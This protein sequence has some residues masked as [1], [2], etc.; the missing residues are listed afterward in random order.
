MSSIGEKKT[1]GSFTNI[2]KKK[3]D[4]SRLLVSAVNE[5]HSKTDCNFF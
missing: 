1:F 5:I 2:R 4:Y 3:C